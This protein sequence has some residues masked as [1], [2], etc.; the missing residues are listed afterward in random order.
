[1]E[2][3]RKSRDMERAVRDRLLSEHRDLLE[4]ALSCADAVT[5]GWD[6]ATTT[7]RDSVVGPYRAT[8]E[9]AG[10]LEALVAAL[11]DAVAAG[12][13]ELAARPVPDI[14]YLA[15]TSRGVVLRAPIGT[16]RVVVTLAAFERDPYRRGP[17]LPGALAIEVRGE[18]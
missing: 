3:H 13:G 9:R 10:L 7:D 17:A 6:G 16:G 4:G 8:L 1:M 5:A 11:A 12:G 2:D 15:V 18:P 14:P